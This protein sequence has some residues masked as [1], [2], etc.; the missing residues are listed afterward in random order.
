MALSCPNFLRHKSTFGNPYK[1]KEKYPF[2]RISKMYQ[3]PN[4]ICLAFSDAYHSGFNMGF[5]LAE[6]VNYGAS[7]WLDKLC[8][9]KGCKC[10]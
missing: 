9:F 4:E 7:N 1:I 2:I 3:T 6:A 8:K 10:P 5:N